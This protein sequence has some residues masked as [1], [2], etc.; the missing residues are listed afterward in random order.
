MDIFQGRMI[1][2]KYII[3]IGYWSPARS[4]SQGED[5]AYYQQPTPH[6]T[7]LVICCLYAS[8]FHRL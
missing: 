4:S 8:S 6:F 5:E 7:L 2:E 1:L 3:N